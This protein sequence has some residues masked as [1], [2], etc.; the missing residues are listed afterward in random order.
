MKHSFLLRICL[1]SFLFATLYSCGKKNEDFITEPL[2]DYLPLEPGKYITYRL[3]SLVFVDFERIR[4]IHRYQL[5]LEVAE[6]FEDNEG[7]PSYRINRW[8]RDSAGL[9]DWENNGTFYITP[10][11]DQVEV[12]ENNL[13]FIKLH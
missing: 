7:R 13:R 1:F 12:V 10:T 11:E 2:S 4:E 3:D 8:L 6:E 9:D 5:K